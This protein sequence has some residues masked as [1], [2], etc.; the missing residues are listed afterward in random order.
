MR[1]SLR[2]ELWAQLC[3][4]LNQPSGNPQ[5]SLWSGLLRCS[6]TVAARPICMYKTDMAIDA[7]KKSKRGRPVVDSEQ[8]GT[9]F[10]RSTLDALD[11]WAADQDIAEPRW[12]EAI[13][14]AL[15]EHLRARGYLPAASEAEAAAE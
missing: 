1:G 8:V 2:A 15:A 12:P 13:G 14:R 4:G 10:E 5:F 3:Y 7:L 6:T 9:R 11:A